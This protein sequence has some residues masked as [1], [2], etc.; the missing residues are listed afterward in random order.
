MAVDD[1]PW[2]VAHDQLK[3][4]MRKEI[5]IMREVLANMLQEELSMQ[6]NDKGSLDHILTERSL[7]IERLGNLRLARLEATKKLEELG[8][9][10]QGGRLLFEGDVNSCEILSLSEQIMALTERMNAQNCR[11]NLLFQHMKYMPPLMPQPQS[12]SKQ[13]LPRTQIGVINKGY[14]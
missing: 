6:L 5:G 10:H 3:D 2:N 8:A 11:N 12:Q 13:S 4:S 7:M 14:E 1:S 9:A